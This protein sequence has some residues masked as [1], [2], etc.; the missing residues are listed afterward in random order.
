VTDLNCHGIAVSTSEILALKPIQGEEPH[1]Q[2]K[3]KIQ[4][5]RT[6]MAAVMR[7]LFSGHLVALQA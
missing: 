7:V 5:K 3:K 6:Q 2:K 1:K 4:G